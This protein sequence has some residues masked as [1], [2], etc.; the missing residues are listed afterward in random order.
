MRNDQRPEGEPAFSFDPATEL[1]SA[2]TKLLGQVRAAGHQS[3]SIVA[4]NEAYDLLCATLHL[5][6][7]A[8]FTP[9]GGGEPV[10]ILRHPL[11]LGTQFLVGE[12]R[13]ADILAE[14]RRYVEAELRAE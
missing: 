12:M 10:P 7:P 6:E 14:V 2:L 8:F 11:M 3:P 4:G 13:Q 1:D 9:V 5:A